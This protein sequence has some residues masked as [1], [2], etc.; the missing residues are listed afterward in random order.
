[1]KPT[2]SRKLAR[3]IARE[4]QN[5]QRDERNRPLMSRQGFK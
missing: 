5:Y 2:E 4:R 3:A 1:M